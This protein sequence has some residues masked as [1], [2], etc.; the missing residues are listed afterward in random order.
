MSRRRGSRL[1]PFLSAVAAGAALAACGGGSSLSSPSAIVPTAPP[2]GLACPALA[3]NGPA[4]VSPAPGSTGV[5]TTLSVLT[6]GRIAGIPQTVSG[7]ATLTGSDGTTITSGPL[8]PS[9]DG[10]T[11]TAS[12]AGLQPHTTYAVTVS[13]TLTGRGCSTPFAANDG[14]FTTQ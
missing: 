6:F 14:N 11:T 9:A 12:V 13:G 10:S 5:P 2:G 1:L 4:L 3:I 7:N 8:T